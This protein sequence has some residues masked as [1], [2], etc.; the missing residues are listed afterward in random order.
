MA[1][2]D[3][4]LTSF[5]ARCDHVAARLKITRATLS[6]RLFNDGKRIEAISGGGS[7]IGLRRLAQ[8]ERDLSALEG[9]EP[10]SRALAR[11]ASRISSEAA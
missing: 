2:P 3:P 8:A 4:R 7:D 11:D 10:T 9:T 5:L 6:S 1:F